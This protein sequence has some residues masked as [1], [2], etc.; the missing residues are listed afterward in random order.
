[1]SL[2]EP[3]TNMTKNPDRKQ[4]A[5]GSMATHWL[6][7]P[8]CG[9]AAFETLTS[10]DRY[11]MGVRTCQCRGCGLAMTNP[12]PLAADL[13]PFYRDDYLL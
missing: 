11:R 13:D 7:C 12:A 1:M 6:D 8:I 2:H 3:P 10:A 9:S 4:I 5:Y